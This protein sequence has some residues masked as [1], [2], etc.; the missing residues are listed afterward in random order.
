MPYPAHLS[1]FPILTPFRQQGCQTR[2]SPRTN[3]DHSWPGPLRDLT[4]LPNWPPLVS[5][6]V[7]NTTH[8]TRQEQR[9]S[10]PTG[11]L[12]LG[13]GALVRYS[14]MGPLW[15]LI[16]PRIGYANLGVPPGSTAQHIKAQ[17][18]TSQHIKAQPSK[19]HCIAR[20]SPA[21]HSA[22]HSTAHQGTAHITAQPSKAH[23]TAQHGTAQHITYW[24][25][26][27]PAFV[28]T[29]GRTYTH[30]RLHSMYRRLADD[31]R[32]A[33][34]CDDLALSLGARVWMVTRGGR[35]KRGVAME[36]ESY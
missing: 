30:A 12:R 13:R 26:S 4:G 11:P 25:H 2:L 21:R 27:G 34:R 31:A 22:R 33:V 7:A 19:T 35:G 36:A 32:G 16:G 5:P 23:R 18:I 24:G 10:R 14:C 20:H 28:S 8:S 6:T 1:I 3:G 15:S 17:H 9:S 29:E